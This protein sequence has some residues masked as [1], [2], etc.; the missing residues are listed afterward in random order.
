[1]MIM[2]DFP[3]L[4]Q[5]LK[6]SFVR[7]EETR[8]TNLGDAQ[9]IPLDDT[10]G[11]TQL[12]SCLGQTHAFILQQNSE[13]LRDIFSEECIQLCV[14]DPSIHM[15]R[16]VRQATLEFIRNLLDMQF[17]SV[18]N[19][20]K[21]NLQIND[22]SGSDSSVLAF[23]KLFD[24]MY[25]AVSEGLHDNWSEI[26]LVACQAAR[27]FLQ[28][29][30]ENDQALYWPKLLPRLCMSRFY[31]AE[32]VKT[33]SHDTWRVV[34][35][36]R[37]KQ[38]IVQHIEFIVPHYIEMSRAKNHMVSEAACL[39]MSEIVGKI[40]PN[41]V[42]PYVS[43]LLEATKGCLLE[44]SWPVRDAACTGTGLFIKN[45]P[46]ESRSYLDLFTSIWSRQLCDSIWSVRENAAFAIGDALSTSD[47]S[48]REEIVSYCSEFLFTHI[49]KAREEASVEDSKKAKISSFLPPEMLMAAPVT[50]PFS[51]MVQ[52]TPTD[53][54]GQESINQPSKKVWRTGGGW[55]CCLDCVV[56]RKPALWESSAG[57]V[58]LLREIL[59]AAGDLT[60]ES[61][62]IE[63]FPRSI[64]SPALSTTGSSSGAASG[65]SGVSGTT[66]GL[67][68]LAESYVDALWGL[69]QIDHFPDAPKLK[70]LVM[71]Q[72]CR[73]STEFECYSIKP[74]Q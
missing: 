46:L 14:H 60:A 49:N 70:L 16:H 65:A 53:T 42:R 57:C 39:A 67:I 61:F 34:I 55:G 50:K 3:I 64:P 12:E 56:E 68:R 38:L 47:I 69:L 5:S 19:I 8:P 45:Y 23:R 18:N 6:A 40:D 59:R 74:S 72:V 24:S 37:G 54:S 28:S 25:D 32:G 48:L 10:T 63:K 4:L 58:V 43:Q 33:L 9:N 41:T 21:I 52:P 11:W 35:K 71:Q 15:S 66:E 62:T 27:S 36:T 51:T 44:T 1:M 7:P 31:A 30:S 2:S 29:L 73:L 17:K 13:V 26:R 20:F 22:T